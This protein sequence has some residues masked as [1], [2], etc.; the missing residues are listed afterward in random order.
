MKKII[1]IIALAGAA[2]LAGCAKEQLPSVPTGKTVINVS[3]EDSKTTIGELTDGRRSI[4]W[5]K[6]DVLCCN[7]KLSEAL[8]ES[9]AGT[10]M[11]N[12]VFND[13]LEEPYN[14]LYPA[15]L[16]TDAS[17]ITLPAVAKY[18]P[19]AGQGTTM[20]ALTGIIK[21]SIEAG[22]DTHKIRNVVVS[23]ATAQLSGAFSIDYAA[24]T[25]ASQSSAD[26]DKSVSVTVNQT[27][28]AEGALELFIPAPAG[29]Y[30][31]TARIIDVEGHYMDVTT[32]SA[33]TIV[34]G[35]VSAF[36]TVTFAPTGTQVDVEITSAEE[37][38]A[39][40]A[41]FNTD[42]EENQG[43]VVSIEADLDFAGTAPT[44]L[45]S[46]TES[47][48]YYNGQIKGNNHKL[49]NIIGTA[50]LIGAISTDCTV[51]DLT[52]DETCSYTVAYTPDAEQYFGTFTEYLKGNLTNCKN[53]ANISLEL[54]SVAS[55]SNVYVGGLV[56]R[57]REGVV[58]N[59]A[60]YGTIT[61]GNTFSSS[62]YSY[63]GGIVGRISNT[64]GK[65]INCTNEGAISTAALS[66]QTHIGGIA[67]LS[68]GTISSCINK[69]SLSSSM[70][71]PS[72]DA[73]KHIFLGGIVSDVTGGTVSQCANKV[74]ITTSSAVKL[75]YIGGIAADVSG[76]ATLENNT[77][78]NN[79][80]STGGLRDTFFGGL[81]GRVSAENTINVSGSPF[82]GK[83]TVSGYESSATSSYI[84]AGGIVGLATKSV[85]II[86][87]G[88]TLASDI[89]VPAS[90]TS[91]T[92][93]MLGGVIG[94]AGESGAGAAVSGTKVT[95]KNISVS[96]KVQVSGSGSGLLPKFKKCCLG[97]VLGGAFSG[98]DIDNCSSSTSVYFCTEATASSSN[99][100][101]AHLGGI[102]GRIEGANSTIT[103]CS[104]SGMVYSYLYN[105]NWWNTNSQVGINAN[106][107]VIGSF[108][109]NLD[110]TYTVSIS[111]CESS[112]T[113]YAYRG[114]AAGIAGYAS[115][116]DISDC[117]F[118]GSI[119][120][121]APA[122]G[123]IGIANGGTVSGCTVKSKTLKGTK[124][125]STFGHTGG[126][127]GLGMSVSVDG[128]KSFVTNHTSDNEAGGIIGSPDASCTI[129]TTSACSFGG[130]VGGVAID[131]SNVAA[132]AAGNAS[133]TI[134]AV[135]TYWNGK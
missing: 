95:I 47:T 58:L 86:G 104:N 13:V 101:P 99:G 15:S 112:G 4:L 59:C 106:G 64:D 31:F 46:Y 42:P 116:A 113:C 117:T 77:N 103:G 40:A 125:G 1:Y 118:T 39:F 81:Y 21:L 129:G 51:S 133:M 135:V 24:G 128:C 134:P 30:S 28:P 54:C 71:R 44:T 114:T 73:C 131:A 17:S 89:T 11:A 27:L 102:A 63:A 87:T 50:A 122:G 127:A 3:I 110:N 107:G 105:N 115:K 67:G 36:P 12:F 23:S 57:V 92:E 20:A 121:G 7:G 49:S 18:V 41:A 29:T 84:F 35:Q 85:T 8:D 53:Y 38:N 69:G 108:G 37:W 82:T 91:L 124:A 52:I 65:V 16:Y 25:I 55:T 62:K 119:S 98:A 90:S 66:A 60:N 80:T 72:G 130:Q 9:A 61:L 123:I 6:G 14:L 96:G 26:A 100:N 74:D 48:F 5:D 75:Q 83:I 76:T 94:A 68:T 45:G 78:E 79:I 56:G 34:A 10:S 97:G 132:K 33:K 88:C 70:A 111:D 19:L 32:T 93:L 22:S 2:L 120:R 109:Y 126:I 43:K